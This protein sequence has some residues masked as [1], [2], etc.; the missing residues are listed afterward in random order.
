VSLRSYGQK[1]P[2]IEFKKETFR[3]FDEMMARIYEQT[4]MLALNLRK[5]SEKAEK[6]EKESKEELEKLSVVHEEFSLVSRKERR[7]NKKI[8]KKKLKVKRQ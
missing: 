1:D 5:I 8:G 6:V 2:I 4:I 7:V 3:M